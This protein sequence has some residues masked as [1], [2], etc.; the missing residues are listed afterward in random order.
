MGYVVKLHLRLHPLVSDHPSYGIV[1]SGTPP[2]LLAHA[3]LVS[4][5]TAIALDEA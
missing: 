4:F 3:D 5:F 2:S 1:L